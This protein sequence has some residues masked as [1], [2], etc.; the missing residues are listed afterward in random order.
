LLH[1]IAHLK[2]IRGEREADAFVI[3]QG[4]VEDLLSFHEEHNKK[5]KKYKKG[6]GLTTKEV[7]SFI[8][9]GKHSNI[10]R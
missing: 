2:G 4:Y 5:F 6:E 7:E 9:N 8:K 1:E 10:Q 3:N